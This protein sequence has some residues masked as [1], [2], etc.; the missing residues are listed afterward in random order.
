MSRIF[1]FSFEKRK[2]EELLFVAIILIYF[3]SEKDQDELIQRKIGNYLARGGKRDIV[4]PRLSRHP[5]R[6]RP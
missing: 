5:N 2:K 6:N 1:I 4:I 3:S